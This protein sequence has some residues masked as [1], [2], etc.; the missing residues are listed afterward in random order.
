MPRPHKSTLGSETVLTKK[1]CRALE[2]LGAVTFAVVGGKMQQAGQPDRTI[3][4]KEL[5]GG[6]AK[7][8]FK[9]ENGKIS[10]LQQLIGV[11]L[12]KRNV[13]C[14]VYW[15]GSNKFTDFD[16]NFIAS[17]DYKDPQEWLHVLKEI[18]RGKV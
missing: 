10:Q 18:G 3:H 13:L 7:V 4:A 2:R 9:S 1:L 12:S 14:V 8:E 5:P 11:K 6:T 17:A 15:F 16:G